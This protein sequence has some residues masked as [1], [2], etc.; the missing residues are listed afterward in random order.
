[1]TASFF[2]VSVNRVLLPVY[3]EITRLLAPETNADCG[4][5]PAFQMF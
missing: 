3:A 1:L 4:F 2:S 5:P